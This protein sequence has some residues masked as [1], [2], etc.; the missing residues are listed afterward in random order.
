[1]KKIVLTLIVTLV[2]FFGIV[3][4][5]SA[6]TGASGS[7]VV[8]GVDT[9]VTWGAI[10]GIQSPAI[11]DVQDIKISPTTGEVYFGG[12]FENSIDST[13]DYIIKYNPETGEYSTLGSDGNEDGALKSAWGQGSPG[14]YSMVFDSAG[15]LYVTGQFEIGETIYDVAKWDG[16]SWSGVGPDNTFGDNT[17]NRGRSIAV[18]SQDNIY[19]AGTFLNVDGN[20][21]ADGIAKWDGENWSSLGNTPI[22]CTGTCLKAVAIGKND[23]VYVGGLRQNLFGIAE[24]DYVAKWNGTEWSALGSNGAGNGAFNNY[25]LAMAVNQTGPED[26]VYLSMDGTELRNGDLVG[27]LIKWDGTEWSQAGPNKIENRYPRALTVTS[28]GG[29]LIGGWFDGG[30]ENNPLAAYFA[31]FDG[32]ETYAL[33]IDSSLDPVF[34]SSV[35]AVAL[36]ADG[37]IYVGGWFDDANLDTNADRI[38]VS[39]A[40]DL[41]P[42]GV[43]FSGRTR[44]TNTSWVG[45]QSI[46]CPAPNPWVKEQLGFASNVK[47]VL[48][49]AENT[50]GKTITQSSYDALKSSGVEF[51]TVS[52]KVFTATETLPLYGCKDKL[53]SG[54]VNQSIQFIAGR[55]TLQSDAHGYINTADQKWHDINGVTLY[56]NTAAFMHTVKFTKTGKYVVVLTEQPDTSAGIS[57]TYGARSIRFVININ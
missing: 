7:E 45:A 49:S 12:T 3:P 26:I 16:T 34:N 39:S 57:P 44:K 23:A 28:N 38:A 33:G 4:P 30:I 41:R 24:A 17:N 47:P 13:G 15:I 50:I 19:V 8:D 53:L 11:G 48:V 1:M 52:K 10:G 14:I 54:K 36:D 29:V 5:A 9:G 2:S 46:T 51:D 35:Q 6:T 31:Y 55:Y 56:T 22:G 37:H 42:V 40:T 43:S 21:A 25:V 18:D 27:Y 32:T 20:E